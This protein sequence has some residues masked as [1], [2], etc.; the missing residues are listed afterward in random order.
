MA[1]KPR[2]SDQREDVYTQPVD[3]PV[4]QAEDQRH[5]K[6]LKPFRHQVRRHTPRNIGMIGDSLQDVGAA[7]SIVLDEDDEILAGAGT[8]EAAAERG[9]LN[10]RVIESDGTEIIAVRRR[11]LTED[12]KIRL[13]LADNRAADLAEYDMAAMKGV[14]AMPNVDPGRFFNDAE[15]RMIEDR[16]L[17]NEMRNTGKKT[18]K[19]TVPTIPDGYTTFSLVLS[20]EASEEIRST[21]DDI[22]VKNALDTAAEALLSLCKAYRRAATTPTD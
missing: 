15:L 5:V 12:Q 7:R 13:A 11:G 22:K 17:A 14:L 10:V 16:E 6:D 20:D 21:L 9:I 18:E 8:I 3:I 4:R 19:E 2:M 1:K